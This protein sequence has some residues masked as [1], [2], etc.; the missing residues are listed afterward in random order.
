[1][2]VV[3]AVSAFAVRLLNT[4]EKTDLEKAAGK[5]RTEIFR[6]VTA[7]QL[8]ERDAY[9]EVGEG[10][11]QVKPSDVFGLAKEM[12]LLDKPKASSNPHNKKF[13]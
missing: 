4:D 13:D 10:K 12:G 5:Q 3:F 7:E 2:F 8:A 1:M 11:V 6:T 9:K